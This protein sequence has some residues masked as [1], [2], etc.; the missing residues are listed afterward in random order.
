MTNRFLMG[1]SGGTAASMGAFMQYFVQQVCNNE[2]YFVPETWRTMVGLTNRKLIPATKSDVQGW[3]KIGGSPIIPSC[4]NTNVFE[5]KKGNNLPIDMSDNVK[6]FCEGYD[7]AVIIG[8]GGTTI[9]STLLNKAQGINFNIPLATMDNDVCCFDDVLG[10]ETAKQYSAASINA[11]S[12]DARTMQRPTIVFSMGYE[13]GRLAVAATNTARRVYGT[14]IDMLHIPE[15]RVAI[16]DVANKIKKDYNGGDYTIVISEGVCKAEQSDQANDNGTHKK[17]DVNDYSE[18]LKQ[19]TGINFKVM[20]PDYVQR[21][22]NPV[23]L[24]L[25]LAKKFAIK[26][27]DLINS[28]KWNYVIGSIKGEITAMPLEKVYEVIIKQNASSAWYTTPKLS[29]E[30]LSDI[31]VK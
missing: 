12:N 24:D 13:C 2:I 6:T 9:Q 26:T 5:I 14:K 18:K 30:K 29:I 27:V 16:E 22:G 25:K 28:G 17:F 23:R 8:G 10:F 15:T 19:L 1:P 21:S 20:I 4:K 31:L 3:D 7:G 11:C